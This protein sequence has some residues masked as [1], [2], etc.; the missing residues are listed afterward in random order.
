MLLAVAAV[1][2]C[3]FPYGAI[4]GFLLTI[5]VALIVFRSWPDREHRRLQVAVGLAMITTLVFLV[6]QIR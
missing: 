6:A 3:L 2:L 4:A 1:V 5:L